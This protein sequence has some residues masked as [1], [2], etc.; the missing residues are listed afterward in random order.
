MMSF[1]FACGLIVSPSVRFGQLAQPPLS[2]HMC[3]P[4]PTAR[5]PSLLTEISTILD[6]T[7][8][9]MFLEEIRSE[10]VDAFVLV[11]GEPAPAAG[12]FGDKPMPKAEIGLEQFSALLLATGDVLPAEKVQAMFEAVDDNGDGKIEFVKYFKAILD[13]VR[14][15]KVAETG[16]GGFLAGLLGR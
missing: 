13:E 4:Q 12:N 3:S 6:D 7:C 9:G 1:A 15:R 16:G 5:E 10:M 14:S 11:S 8:G 2:A